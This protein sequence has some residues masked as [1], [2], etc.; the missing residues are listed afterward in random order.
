MSRAPGVIDVGV[1]IDHVRVRVNPGEARPRAVEPPRPARA[2]DGD[3]RIVVRELLVDTDAGLADV[4][5]RRLGE[6]VARA[7]GEGLAAL[8]ARRLDAILSGRSRGG[9]V[10]VGLL[11]AVLRG[12]RA[13]GPDA[14]AVAAALC[15]AVERRVM[16]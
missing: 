14:R 1:V 12:E 3:H 9:A 7:L 16:P 5:A 4:E 13:D 6:R 2:R 11:R 15:G 10:R 8:Q